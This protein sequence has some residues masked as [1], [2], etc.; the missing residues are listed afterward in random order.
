MPAA[1]KKSTTSAR[2]KTTVARKTAPAPSIPGEK[3][4]KKTAKTVALK[5]RKRAM[6]AEALHP[7]PLDARRQ[8]RGTDDPVRNDVDE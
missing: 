3:R 1:R 4:V 8:F 5:P 2:K 7:D 6:K